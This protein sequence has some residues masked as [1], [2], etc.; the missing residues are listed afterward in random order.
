[1]EKVEA[2]LDKLMPYGERKPPPP[3]SIDAAYKER[4]QV[5]AELRAHI[6]AQAAEIARWKKLYAEMSQGYLDMYDDNKRL[7]KE[8]ARKDAA[9]NYYA[10]HD[11]E[12]PERFNQDGKPA[13]HDL[14][15]PARRALAPAEKTPSVCK[16]CGEK[17]CAP[18]FDHC[19]G[20]DCIPF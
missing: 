1:M 8:V 12:D 9:L 4:K 11:W 20:D 6:E 10:D 7:Q 2:L 14:A 17:P 16:V 15:L 13:P 5:L 18:G 3:V 19:K